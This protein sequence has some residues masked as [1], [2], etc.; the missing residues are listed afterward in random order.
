MI[1]KNLSLNNMLERED[2]LALPLSKWKELLIEKDGACF[3]FEL[4]EILLAKLK[5]YNK[6]S[7]VNSFYY[8]EDKEWLDKNTRIGLQNLI[9]CGADIITL[10][11]K[12]ELL[13]ISAEELKLFL[14]KLEVY[15]GK[16]FATTAKHQQAINQ[17]YTT[18]D[19]INYDF[20]ANYPKKV[21]LK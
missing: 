21:R 10:Q 7:E 19:L 1:D 2:L 12:K 17:L 15:A 20:T 13:D 18:E 9:N 6:S 3:D 14:N 11:L 8:G 5:A 4:R 16:C